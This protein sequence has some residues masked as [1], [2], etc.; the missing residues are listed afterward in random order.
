MLSL[1]NIVQVQVNVASPASSGSAFSTGL[2]IA[3]SSSTPTAETRLRLFSSAADML[4]AGFTQSDP[5]YLAAAAYFAASPAPDRVY[6][7]L[8]GSTETAASAFQQFLGMTSDFYGVCLCES[9]A[10]KVKAFAEA[11]PA[12]SGRFMAFFAGTGTVSEATGSSGVLKKLHDLG[13]S[14]MIGVYGCDIYAAAALMGTAM[15]LS[16]AYSD[17]SFALCYQEVPGMLPVDLTESQIAS[18][19]ALNANVYI[20]RGVSRRL[21]ENGSTASGC[22]FDEV[23]ALDRIS[24]DL[25]EAALS[26]IT[27]GSGKLPQTDETSAVFINRF[28][29]ILA[30]YAASGVLA[31]GV[32][33]GR[34][35]GNLQPGDAVENGYLLWAES[36]D[37]Q[38][39]ADRAAHK[40][41]P[42]HAALCLSGS[43]ESLL[44]DI[45]VMM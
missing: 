11:L 3:A 24:A 14:R 15:G 19:K 34:A 35:V 5:A 32:W 37:L 42:I 8:T 26:L 13:S 40:A 9:N 12:I 17:A 4:S 27:S 41:M 2:I 16:R 43:V 31:T 23:L 45:D 38:S 7:G 30:G 6:V 10:T 22:R 39:D 1:S 33:R 29:A 28:S 20:T 21:L 18:F 25:Q 44:I 36:Y